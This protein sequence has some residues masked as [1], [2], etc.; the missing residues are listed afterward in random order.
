MS[1][2]HT[3]LLQSEDVQEQRVCRVKS[4]PNSESL[5]PFLPDPS[6]ICCREVASSA[7]YFAVLF[8]SSIFQLNQ[9]ASVSAAGD[10]FPVLKIVL[11]TLSVAVAEVYVYASAVNVRC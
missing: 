4:G 2:I 9:K 5:L 10:R 11:M 6:G 8:T 3:S 1:S 7:C